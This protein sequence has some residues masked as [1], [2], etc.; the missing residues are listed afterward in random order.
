MHTGC[1]NFVLFLT[2]LDPPHA[3]QSR[4][5]TT[6]RDPIVQGDTEPS[7]LH[8]TSPL[9]SQI[10]PAPS[11][12]SSSGTVPTTQSCISQ[13]QLSSSTHQHYDHPETI[14]RP[15]LPLSEIYKAL[16]PVRNYWKQIGTLFGCDFATLTDIQK[17][18]HEDSEYLMEMLAERLKIHNPPLSWELI[19]QVV[20]NFHPLVAQNIKTEYVS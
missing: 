19:V 14:G 18:G 11:V 16:L 1:F 8:P 12:A 7:Q 2:A 9:Q 13:E 5:T 17:R 6:Q 4:N 20:N 15:N 10:P 3:S